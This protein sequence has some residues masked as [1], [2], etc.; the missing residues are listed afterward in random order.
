MAKVT[1]GGRSYEVEVRGESV[2]VDG[3]E[4]PIKLRQEDG[5]VTVKAGDQQYRVHLP[6]EDQRQSGLT[7]QVD[8]RPVTV[9]WEGTLG[10]APVRAP[11]V[12]GGPATAAAPRVA[13]DGRGAPRQPPSRPRSPP[14]RPATSAARPSRRRPTG[15]PPR[16][17]RRARVPGA[18]RR[19][20]SVRVAGVALVPIV[21]RGAG[22][23]HT[24]ST[25]GRGRKAG[26][27]SPGCAV[28]VNR[29]VSPGSLPVARRR[30]VPEGGLEPPTLRL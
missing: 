10:A 7:A 23:S 26:G 20:G 19:H 1:I 29:R 6:A 11:R 17:P 18:R 4:F 30:L 2:V 25:N 3:K 5:F 12:T 9:A 22:D 16:V 15:P 8:Y 13:T 24:V 21:C 14:G 27:R 28:G